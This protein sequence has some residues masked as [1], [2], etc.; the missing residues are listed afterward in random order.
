MFLNN[1]K[2][3]LMLIRDGINYFNILVEKKSFWLAYALCLGFFDV[4]SAL[5]ATTYPNLISN[6][7]LIDIYIGGNLL[8]FLGV[9]TLLILTGKEKVFGYRS[10]GNLWRVWS[11]EFIAGIW[12]LLGFL[13]FIIPGLLLAIRYIYVAEIALLE[14]SRISQTLIKSRKLS[15]INGGKVVIACAFVFILYFL[16]VF[17]LSFVIALI[18]EATL[19]SFAVNYFLSVSSTLIATL[20]CT[21]VY[22]GYLN[23]L[24]YESLKE[25][26]ASAS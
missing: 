18:N 15:S 1:P 7:L 6:Q 22:S 9:F 3:P 8:I 21:I 25:L 10:F 19:D 13:C 11:T 12:V 17:A 23:A 4:V 16:L 5:F 20:W 24:S 14:E 26:D 2:G